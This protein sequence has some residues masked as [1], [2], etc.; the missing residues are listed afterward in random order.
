MK[1]PNNGE[2]RV[3]R[4]RAEQKQQ[5]R[6]VREKQLNGSWKKLRVIY[7]TFRHSK[8]FMWILT[9]KY[10]RVYNKYLSFT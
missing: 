10:R 9:S 4:E 6:M 7:S 1:Y 3:N 2:N 8:F 5:S